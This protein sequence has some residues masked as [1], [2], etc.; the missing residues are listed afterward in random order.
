MT[1]NIKTQ[2]VQTMNIMELAGDSE[3]IKW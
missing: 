2:L 3:P 1:N